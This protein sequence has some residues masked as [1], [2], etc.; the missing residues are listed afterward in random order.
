MIIASP[1]Y[2]HGISGSMKNALDWFGER[3]GISE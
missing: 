1:E 2:A 3:R